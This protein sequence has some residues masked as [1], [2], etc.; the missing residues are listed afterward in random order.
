MAIHV[1]PVT[2][3]IVGFLGSRYQMFG[4]TLE[5]AAELESK[6]VQ[7][8]VHLSQVGLH[9]A[10]KPLLSHTATEEL[11]N[12]PA[13]YLRTFSSTRGGSACRAPRAR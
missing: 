7:G 11:L 4:H 3:G 12:S 8:H 6:C 5:E 13:S 10:V 2:A 1:G 9:T